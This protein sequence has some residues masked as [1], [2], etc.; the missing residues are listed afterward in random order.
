MSDG[1]LWQPT[2]HGQ[3]QQV[4][5]R[6]VV[7]CMSEYLYH[8]GDWV[9][10]SDFLTAVGLS[11]HAFVCPDGV[12]IRQ[13]R[14][15]QGAWHAKGFNSHSLGV[16]VLV[17]GQW[18]YGPWKTR[19]QTAYMTDPQWGA[20]VRLV[21]NWVNEWG[22]SQIDRHSDIDPDRKTD[23]GEGFP[24]NNFLEEVRYQHGTV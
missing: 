3:G 5:T 21:R 22:I 11:A 10:A 4:P 1:E 13:R 23:P 9:H 12:I 24:W 19:I 7:H 8:D 20:T 17:D 16:E 6:I 15:D 14:D 18:T 2:S